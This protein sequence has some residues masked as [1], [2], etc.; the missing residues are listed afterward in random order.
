MPAGE[1]KPNERYNSRFGM[2]TSDSTCGLIHIQWHRF[3]ADSCLDP[4]IRTQPHPAFKVSDLTAAL[5]GCTV[6]LEPYEPI[7]GLRVAIIEDAGWPIELIQ[8][9]LSDD[10]IWKRAKSDP[11]PSD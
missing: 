8:T 10:E 4:R 6:L 2:Y 5:K 11:R 7:E 9:A 1:V 3:N